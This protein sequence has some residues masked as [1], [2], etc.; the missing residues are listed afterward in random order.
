MSSP[1]RHIRRVAHT[2]GRAG[3]LSPPA[4]AGSSARCPVPH[5][6][7]LSLSAPPTPCLSAPIAGQILSVISAWM[8]NLLLAS[9]PL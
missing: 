5:S 2:P 4:A 7:P 8:A 6:S 1:P 9:A 3:R